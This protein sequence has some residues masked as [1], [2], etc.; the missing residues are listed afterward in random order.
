MVGHSKAV[1][2]VA[3]KPNRPYRA[4]TGGE[5]FK[6]IHYE[7]PPF[8]FKH[9][10]TGHTNFVN[11]VAYAPNG[12]R[13]ATVS[14]DR[15]GL[16]FD[17]K[18]G[19]QVGALASEGA[20][21]GGLYGCVFSPD[22]TQL[23][24][25][26]GDKT[27]KLWD[28]A[29]GALIQTFTFGGDAPGIGDMQCAVAWK[30]DTMLSLSVHGDINLLDPSN[31]AQPRRVVQSQQGAST[32]AAVDPESGTIAVGSQ[33][34]RAY[35]WRDGVGTRVTGAVHRNKC[36]GV[37]IAGD[38]LLSV[39]LDDSLRSAS[40][41]LGTYEAEVRTTPP[42]LPPL[43]PA[44]TEAPCSADR[45]RRGAGGPRAGRT[46]A[47]AGGHPHSQGR[48]RG[49]GHAHRGQPPHPVGCR[50][51]RRCPG[52]LARGSQQR[53]GA[54]RHHP[55]LP[56]RGRADRGWDAGRPPCVL[57]GEGAACVQPACADLVPASQAPP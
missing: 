10:C 41:T 32:C 19:E 1:N 54:L 26:S 16:L 6:V 12:E 23:L 31:P 22:S 2:S 35:L 21:A 5:D 8:K 42:S 14:A 47:R 33:D 18:T 39:G 27:C 24:T 55:L 11:C 15:T 17:G 29:S 57:A 44:C 13:Y 20:H 7:G 51:G 9:S 30:Q 38:S 48:H 50:C 53:R 4:V 45:G 49:A 34:G 28:A 56:G 25:A 40:L 3:I 37:A 36:V 52:R 46:R 43:P